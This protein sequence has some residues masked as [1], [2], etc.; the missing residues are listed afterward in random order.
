MSFSGMV[1]EELSRQI[2]TG[3]T[4]QDCRNGCILVPVAEW[5]LELQG[6]NP[7]YPDGK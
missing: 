2:S 1:K 7:A 5:R 3:K 4:L 6:E